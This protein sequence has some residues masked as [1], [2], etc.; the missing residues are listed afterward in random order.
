MT[1]I[2]VT[3]YTPA[4]WLLSYPIESQNLNADL[5]MA[6]FKVFNDFCQD[7]VRHAFEKTGR[8][9]HHLD[10]TSYSGPFLPRRVR[11]E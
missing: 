6:L 10:V 4:A 7:I 11:G 5:Q 8:E 9:A 2:S 3:F 1:R